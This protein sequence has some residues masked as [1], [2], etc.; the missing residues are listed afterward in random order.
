[1]GAGAAVA[2]PRIRRSQRGIP[3]AHHHHHDR[4]AFALYLKVAL[5]GSRRVEQS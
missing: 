5:G 1:L 2:G 4:E 3:V